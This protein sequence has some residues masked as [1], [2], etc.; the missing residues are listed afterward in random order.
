MYNGDIVIHIDE[1]LDDHHIHALEQAL[2]E[3]AGIYSACANE[4]ARHLLLVDYDPHALR[5]S[6]IV[7][8]VRE[9]GLH[10]EMIGF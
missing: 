8:A 7:H 4:K 3:E 6:D 10:A 9:R 2:G 1:N 5:P